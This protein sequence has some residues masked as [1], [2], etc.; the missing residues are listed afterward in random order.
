MIK[1]HF[2]DNC[3]TAMHRAAFAICV[4]V[5]D[6]SLHVEFSLGVS[7]KSFFLTCP[8][9]GNAFFLVLL[10][11]MIVLQL[12]H[13]YPISIFSSSLNWLI[14]NLVDMIFPG[15]TQKLQWKVLS[16]GRKGVHLPGGRS[17]VNHYTRLFLR[18]LPCPLTIIISPSPSKRS[19]STLLL[20]SLG[21]FFNCYITLTQIHC[22]HHFPTKQLICRTVSFT[23][24]HDNEL[25]NVPWE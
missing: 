10:H 23:H 12:C 1:R 13:K 22:N 20:C 24:I 18:S 4:I 6:C 25:L 16:F 17:D 2:H 9:N 21:F 15:K 11:G 19:L 14:L 8:V 5:V 7:R 3:E